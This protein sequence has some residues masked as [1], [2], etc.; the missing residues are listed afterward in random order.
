MHSVIFVY[1]MDMVITAG[2]S[3]KNMDAF[4]FLPPDAQWAIDILLR[5]RDVVGVS[6]TNEYIFCRLTSDTP[7]S[8]NSDMQELAQ[9]CSGLQY[10]ERITS[11]NLRKYIATVSQVCITASSFSQALELSAAR[12][13]L[14][15]NNS[16]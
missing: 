15:C 4:E 5:T 13:A 1:R 6:K 7:L 14:T 11:T 10:P 3:K 12:R 9:S 8:G 2:K 16:K